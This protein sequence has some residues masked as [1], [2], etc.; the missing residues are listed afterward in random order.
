MSDEQKV[1]HAEFHPEAVVDERVR[2][3]LLTLI[4]RLAENP[5]EVVTRDLLKPLFRLLRKEKSRSLPQALALSIWVA[6]L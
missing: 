2:A 3:S 1:C 4:S 6:N 5:E